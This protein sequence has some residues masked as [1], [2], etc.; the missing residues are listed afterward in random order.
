[1]MNFKAIVEG[2]LFVCGDEGLSL[3]EI[4]KLIEKDKNETSLII[5]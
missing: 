1:M 4:S 3:D 5:K 2:L